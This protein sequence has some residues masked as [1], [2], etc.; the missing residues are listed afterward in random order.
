MLGFPIGLVTANVGEWLIHKYV[1]HEHGKR[2]GA[3]YSH[4]WRQHHRDARRNEGADHHYDESFTKTTPRLR[5]VLGLVGIGVAIAP[6]APVFPFFC[7][8]IWTHEAAYHYVHKRGH[9]DPTWMRERLP[10]HYDHHMGRNQHANW[11]VVHPLADYLF[12]TREPWAGTEEEKAALARI[13]AREARRVEAV[14]HEID[15]TAALV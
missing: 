10:W 14:G 4:H 11:C 1:L 5:E 9:Q 3:Y 8:G 7:L 13:R 2:E 6:L 12:G 15:E